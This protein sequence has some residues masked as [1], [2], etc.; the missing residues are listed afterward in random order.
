LKQRKIDAQFTLQAKG[1]ALCKAVD[2]A[3]P[4]L[5]LAYR[6]EIYFSFLEEK[7]EVEFLTKIIYNKK[8]GG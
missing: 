3:T 7:D 6:C 2:N 4:V 5:S 8:P 1:V